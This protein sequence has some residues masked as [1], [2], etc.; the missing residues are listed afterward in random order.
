M[1]MADR[2]AVMDCGEIAQIASPR[3]L[4][5]RPS[6]VFVADFIG[7]SNLIAG[8]AQGDRIVSAQGH[9]LAR[10]AGLTE[11]TSCTVSIR[12]EQI[13]ISDNGRLNGTVIST[14]FYGGDALVVVD[15]AGLIVKAQLSGDTTLSIGNT[16]GLDWDT[17]GALVL[18]DEH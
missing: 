9:E 11:G 18:N 14:H 1:S 8:R 16:C 2:I 3:D 13:R 6:N 12:P 10:N 4:Y 15:C 7:T 17:T 5:H